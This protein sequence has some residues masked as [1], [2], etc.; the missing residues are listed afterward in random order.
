MIVVF[1]C[2]NYA[3]EPIFRVIYLSIFHLCSRLLV[4]FE[5]GIILGMTL[6]KGQIQKLSAKQ[7]SFFKIKLY[8]NDENQSTKAIHVSP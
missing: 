3:I 8:R 7:T 6:L 4:L 2:N 5:T 1:P